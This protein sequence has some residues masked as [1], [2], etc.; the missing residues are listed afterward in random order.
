MYIFFHV[1]N[2]RFWICVQPGAK[3]EKITP[4]PIAG[5]RERQLHKERRSEEVDTGVSSGAYSGRGSTSI[6]SPTDWIWWWRRRPHPPSPLDAAVEASDRAIPRAPARFANVLVT[7]G[8][9]L[10]AKLEMMNTDGKPPNPWISLG[11]FWE[12]NFH[13]QF[14]SPH[15]LRGTLHHRLTKV[16]AY[17]HIESR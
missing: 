8:S 4:R 11:F 15:F 5:S 10:E 16:L 2:Q 9:H 17:F 1:V 13:H 3:Q 14:S 12:S 6:H 7:R